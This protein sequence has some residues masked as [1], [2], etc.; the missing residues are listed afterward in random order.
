MN[1][2]NMGGGNGFRVEFLCSFV[3]VGFFLA[4]KQNKTSCILGEVV[5]G[6]TNFGVWIFLV[7][8]KKRK[9]ALITNSWQSVFT[10][11]FFQRLSNFGGG[12]EKQISKRDKLH[13]SNIDV[14]PCK[15]WLGKTRTR[16]HTNIQT[17]R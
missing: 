14:K 2:E 1:R 15:T 6:E 9:V 4:G 12:E 10:L 13:R 8:F 5:R 17:K 3:R 11:V 16:T 7:S